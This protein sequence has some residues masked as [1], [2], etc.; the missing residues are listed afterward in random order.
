MMKRHTECNTPHPEVLGIRAIIGTFTVIVQSYDRKAEWNV[1]IPNNL[2]I[3]TPLYTFSC[4]LLS[5]Q[6]TFFCIL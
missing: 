3:L 6:D 4:F 1:V 2:N 5:I